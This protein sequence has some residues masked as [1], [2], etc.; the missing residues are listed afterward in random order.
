[1]KTK[2]IHY[3]FPLFL[4]VYYC[5]AQVQVETESLPDLPPSITSQPSTPTEPALPPTATNTTAE[6]AALPVFSP[7]TDPEELLLIDGLDEPMERLRL[8]DQDTNMILDMIQLI[9]NRHILR[10]QN[11]P[12]VK[13]TFDSMSVLT[14]RETLLAVESLLAMNGIA[15]TKINE[16][17]YKAVPAQGA[18]VHV[19][20]WLDVPASSLRPSQRIYMKLFRLNYA[21][22]LEVRE[23][24][25]AFATPNVSNLL[26]FEKSN[27]ILI[28][29]SLLNLQRMEEVL[30]E[31]DKPVTRDELGMKWEV[32]QTKYAGAKELENKLKSLI[33][34]SFK[35][36]LGGTTQVDAD[37]RT[38]KLLIVTR[39]E[40][41][42]T[43]EY[44]LNAYD[45]PIKRTTTNKHF[46]LQHAEAKEIQAILDE[47]IKKQQ[48]VK[49]QI[50]G[51][52]TGASAQN[53]T[54][55]QKN[56]TTPTADSG[57]PE[58]KQAHEFSDYVTISSDERSNAILVYGTKD[59][60][61]EIG[62]MIE[63]LDQPLP[64]ARIDTIFV[65]V[66]LSDEN[67]RGID[68]LFKDLEWSEKKV[69]FQEYEVR[70]SSGLPTGEIRTERIETPS[71][72]DGTLQIP[73]INSPLGFSLTNWKLNG[74][75][76]STIFSQATTRNDVRI[77][78]SPSLM[79]S[80]N[81]EKV[82]IMIEDERSF[83]TPY[84]YDPYRSGANNT[85]DN[86]Q[87]SP[88]SNRDMLSAKTSLEISKPKIGLNVYKTDEN[89][90]FVLDEFGRRILEKKGSI[91]M[92]VEI[93]AEKFDETNVNVYEGQELPAKKN[94]EAK[95]FL[96]LKDGE[97]VALGGLQ[98]AQ[99]DSTTA[100][101]RFL[102][103]IPYFGE[104]FF[105]P[106]STKYTPTE[107]L[108]FIK[109]TIVDPD[110]DNIETVV[111]R[112]QESSDLINEK[113][114][115]RS[116]PNFQPKFKFLDGESY[117]LR[118][119]KPFEDSFSEQDNKS[120]LPN[121]F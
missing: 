47:V 8:R 99:Y 38:G 25:N 85:G 56:P 79:V 117:D 19:P 74:I 96:T 107:L 63:D 33:E 88:G 112:I 106:N 12:A 4:G 14:K 87:T 41:W 29:D 2:F 40:N 80:H 102:S 83:V 118:T 30:E 34:G 10:P 3:F 1:M 120:P 68:A 13:V 89:G 46:S 53:A 77:F 109:P 111:N 35:P 5:Y 9:T 50:Q 97:I 91:F 119:M 115:M 48:Q 37:E 31:I 72:L 92:E 116:R 103:D 104:K 93:K 60:I 27:S 62:R 66:D 110:D 94:R 49:Q 21:P 81:S 44:I 70:D 67:S 86:T 84:Y 11:L 98:E 24:L 101:Y 114:K 15:I 64:L 17:F 108:I 6:D 61:E 71:S 65:M 36:F 76:W 20:I 58:S 39:E 22:A 69:E 55:N 42:S 45:A 113:I 82:H 43:I 32:W 23:Q 57:T 90:S 52:K 95:T 59:D 51:R 26:V 121:L 105:T 7:L 16:K 100:K 54:Q 28:T 18:T 73:G 78:S 75:S